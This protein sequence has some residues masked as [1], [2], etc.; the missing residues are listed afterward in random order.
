MRSSQDIQ[1]V[2]ALFTHTK[3]CFGEIA[4]S[5]QLGFASETRLSQKGVKP[6]L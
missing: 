3:K 6:F 5:L 1:K 4:V 2:F